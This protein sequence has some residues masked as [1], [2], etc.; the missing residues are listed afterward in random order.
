PDYLTRV[1]GL[2]SLQV[3]DVVNWIALPQILLVPL[4]A[5]LLRYIDARLTLALGLALIAI[6]SWMDT[7][8]THDWV[9]DDFLP[10]QLVEAVGLALGITSLIFFAIA[11][12]T[13][14]QAATAAGVIQASRLL[15]N[16]IG[17]A[18]IQ[19]FVRV[20]EQIDS[21]LAGLSLMPGGT[22]T[23]GALTQLSQL[24]ADGAVGT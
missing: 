7:G 24:F 4:I 18:F 19:T 14:A 21:N 12:L 13:P 22:T 1:Q 15:G 6:G 16:E 20:R 23:E 2:R 17:L 8:L 5:W 11:T 10:S 3:A 9:N